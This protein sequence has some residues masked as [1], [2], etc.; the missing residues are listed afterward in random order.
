MSLSWDEYYLGIAHAASLKSKDSTQVGAV[1]VGADNRIISLGFNGP[2]KRLKDNPERL[3]NRDPA[4]GITKYHV[5]VHAEMNA[6]LYARRDLTGATLYCTH[7]PCAEC[8]KAIIASGIAHV[9]SI[10]GTRTV[11]DLNTSVTDTLFKEASVG[12]CEVHTSTR[13]E[14]RDASTGPIVA[15]H[16]DVE[17]YDTAFV[18]IRRKS[19][20]EIVPAQ[21]TLRW[22][23]TWS[24]TPEYT[25]F[26]GT[27]VD[28]VTH[29]RYLPD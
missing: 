20:A 16:H 12:F 15:W 21:Y 8:A 4:K 3:A 29:W 10:G 22:D 11:M 13:K 25:L 9:R 6:I 14:W 24:A 18:L 2:P 26:D 23:D 19:H 5:A 27:V 7:R 17:K 1:I 28:D